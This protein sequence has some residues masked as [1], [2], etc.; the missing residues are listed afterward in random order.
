MATTTRPGLRDVEGQGMDE[1][2]GD[3]GEQAHD[4]DHRGEQER[5]CRLTQTTDVEHRDDD[6][7]AQAQQH[8]MRRQG[9]KGGHESPHA[10]GDGHRHGEGVVDDQ[11]GGRHLADG[12]AEVGARDTA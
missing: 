12:D 1:P 2:D 4:E 11:G 9:G 3:D 8:R 5:P 6:Q 10:G 7:D